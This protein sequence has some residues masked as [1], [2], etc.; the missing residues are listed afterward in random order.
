MKHSIGKYRMM[1]AWSRSVG[2]LKSIGEM[3]PPVRSMNATP[4]CPDMLLV[5]AANHTKPVAR[6]AKTDALASQIK[7]DGKSR[8]GRK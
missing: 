5:L 4:Q 7:S 1:S 2:T 8:P 6:G 3:F